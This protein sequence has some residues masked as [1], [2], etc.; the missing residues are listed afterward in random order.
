MLKKSIAEPYRY[1]SIAMRAAGSMLSIESLFRIEAVL[2][3]RRLGD[4]RN[5]FMPTSSLTLS[6]SRS[7]SL[8]MLAPGSSR[9]ETV[10]RLSDRWFDQ[11]DGR[12]VGAHHDRLATSTKPNCVMPLSDIYRR[13]PS[14]WRG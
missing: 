5:V 14:P 3:R 9:N 7:E 2:V 8:V 4:V 11:H 10:R 6:P 12:A 13:R 1:T